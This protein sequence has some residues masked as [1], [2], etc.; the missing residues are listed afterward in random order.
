M[1][2][3]SLRRFATFVGLS[4]EEMSAPGFLDVVKG[5]DQRFAKRLQLPPLAGAVLA[6]AKRQIKRYAAVILCCLLS[7]AVN[8]DARRMP[9]R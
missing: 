8:G 6:S 4:P 5:M 2:T 9:Q 3:R 7:Q 1:L